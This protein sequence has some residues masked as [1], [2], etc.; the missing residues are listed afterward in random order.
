M[1]PVKAYLKEIRN[2]PLLTAEEE[3]KLS[4]KAKAGDQEARK[5]MIRSNLRLVINI[6]KHYRYLNVPIL[7]LIEE[8]NLGLMKAVTKFNPSRGHRFSTY[9]SWW[10][11][12]YILRALS[13]Q[14]KTIRIPVY[15]VEMIARFKRIQERMAQ[16]KKRRPSLSEVAKEMHLPLKR[17]RQLNRLSMRIMSLDVPIDAEGS[18]QIIDLI[19]DEKAK[20]SLDELSEYLRHE[21]VDD[22]LSRM[23][24]RERDILTMRFGLKDGVEYTLDETAKKFGITRERI[25]Q[26]E[27]RAIEKLRRFVG[28]R[29]E[30]YAEF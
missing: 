14:A 16:K 17:V 23:T 5:K 19:Q 6:A 21:R 10:I 13:N 8:G 26:I 1:D 30:D 11:K 28:P 12:Q 29:R 18:A 7:D 24:E 2:I 25:R 27:E 4:N 20:T 9:A 15:M 3:V 22:L